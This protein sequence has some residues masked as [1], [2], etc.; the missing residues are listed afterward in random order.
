MCESFARRGT[1]GGDAPPP[2]RQLR[3]LHR[4]RWEHRRADRTRRAFHV[5]QP[6]PVDMF[7]IPRMSRSAVSSSSAA[8]WRPLRCGHLSSTAAAEA[9]SGAAMLVPVMSRNA[10]GIGRG[11]IDTRRQKEAVA[12]LRRVRQAPSRQVVQT[13]PPGCR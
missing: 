2:Q 6:L 12:D 11:D 4:R 5:Q 10:A 8:S 13:F 9:T 1:E 3:R 7:G